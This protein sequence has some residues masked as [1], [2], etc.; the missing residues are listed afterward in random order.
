MGPSID[1]DAIV[2]L[3]VQAVPDLIAVYSFGS[4]AS[5]QARESSDVDLAVLA[6]QP[7]PSVRRFEL[8]Q[9]LA[10]LL[11]R[12]VDLVDLRGASTVMRMQVIAT[13]GC[14]YSGDD[15]GRQRFEGYVYSSY[16]RLNEERREILKDVHGR[17]LV[18]GR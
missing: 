6:H 15:G 13:G 8:E 14:L 12:E 10:G 1:H 2:R 7:L 17:G 9:E 5:G 18:Y 16:A 4:Q 11:H 3:L